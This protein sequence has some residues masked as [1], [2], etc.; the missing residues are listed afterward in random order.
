MINALCNQGMRIPGWKK[1]RLLQCELGYV[2]GIASSQSEVKN[3][4]SALLTSYRENPN[5]GENHGHSPVCT[6][7]P[8]LRFLHPA[9]HVRV[10]TDG[11][12]GLS[13]LHGADPRGHR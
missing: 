3:T 11:P 8:V 10:H 6:E 9:P 5:P 4:D 7:L 12:P 2:C 1:Q 13:P